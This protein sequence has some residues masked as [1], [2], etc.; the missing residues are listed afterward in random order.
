MGYLIGDDMA[1]LHPPK[2]AGLWARRACEIVGLP[3][4]RY[5]DQ[6]SDD[7]PPG[8]RYAMVFVRHPVAW[9]KSFWMFH[10]RTGW[11]QYNDEPGFIFYANHRAGESFPDF[12]ARYLDKMPG[13]IG[14]M[15]GR[16][17]RNAE[18]V[19]KVE[20]IR[21]DMRRF[22][23]ERHPEIDTSEIDRMAQSN[24]S[25]GPQRLAV[26]FAAG[27]REAI[28]LAENDF[29]STRGYE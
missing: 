14:R 27:Q 18:R 11:E 8:G 17:E 4:V 19:G 23:A 29:M 2:T 21:P 9:L 5:G 13:A 16:Y 3:W 26:N 12:V 6:H 15:F 10:E 22:I 25:P 1:L 20:T 7:P 24:V 28:C